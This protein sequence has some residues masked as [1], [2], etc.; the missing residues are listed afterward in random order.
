[1]FISPCCSES[2]LQPDHI[3]SMLKGMKGYELTESD[4]D[5]IKNMRENELLKKHQVLYAFHFVSWSFLLTVIAFT[6]VMWIW[7]LLF[8]QK[9]LEV[10]QKS[11]KQEELALE[12]AR[13]SRDMALAEMNKVRLWWS[14]FCLVT[15]IL[16]F[17]TSAVQWE[18]KAIFSR[19]NTR[20]QK[21]LHCIADTTA[22]LTFLTTVI[23]FSNVQVFVCHRHFY[24]HFILPL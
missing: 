8:W 10:V 3:N 13:A 17:K 7:W 11:L 21:Q 22:D 1:M 23:T 2:T 4:L 15:D 20:F 6:D 5:F 9:E 14:S 18:V 12:Q 24:K 16:S 19:K